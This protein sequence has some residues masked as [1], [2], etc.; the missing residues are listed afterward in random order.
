MSY[1][2]FLED[3]K[4]IDRPIGI[5]DGYTL[6]P[7]LFPFQQDCVR[8][9]LRRGR[10]GLFE[11]CGLGKSFQQLEWARVISE[12]KDG[13]RV[14]I[15]AP[16][17]VAQ[18][19]VL[20]ATKLGITVKYCRNQAEIETP[21]TI[22]NYEMLHHFDA[23]TFAGVVLDESSIL[24]NFT[25]KTR[26]AIIEAFAETR[27]KLSCTAT[28]APNDYMELGNQAEFLGV[29]TRA[30][31]LAMYFVHDGGDTSEWRLKGHAEEVFWRWM[32]TWAVCLQ[33]PSDIGHSDDGY[34][35]PPLTI[36]KHIFEAKITEGFLLAM[37]AETLTDQRQAKR[38]GLRQ[39]V[40]T[41]ARMA[42]TLKEPWVCWGELNDECNELE[43]L[44]P[45]SVQVAGADSVEAKESRL[46]GFAAGKSRVMVSKSSIAGFG[47]NWQHC[48]NMAFV[49]LS[50]SFEDQYQAIRRCWRFGQTHPVNVHLFLLESEIAI[51]ENVERKQREADAMAANMIQ[52]M[53]AA[54]QDE[55]GA[56][57]RDQT[58]YTPTKKVTLPSWMQS[59]KNTATDGLSTTATRA[60]SSKRSPTAK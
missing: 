6:N 41:C 19:T 18:Q 54:M 10:A 1:A 55:L 12:H 23:H 21:I 59:T 58:H 27:F 53:K 16:L 51:L 46:M 5:L 37:P 34:E 20:E 48:W 13:G 24:K 60:K 36:H 56:L 49:N 8:F 28:P 29:M 30:E 14:L 35:L 2:K 26:N 11:D 9:A 47:L 39:R 50:H 38:E 40:E 45:D 17:A 52:F 32:C 57:K 3:K 15:L 22:T 44:I 25:G 43:K 31:M 42:N 33:R 7:M 4:R